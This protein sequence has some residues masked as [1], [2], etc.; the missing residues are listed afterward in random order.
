MELGCGHA[1]GTGEG[2]QLKR[3]LNSRTV[4]GR[5]FPLSGLG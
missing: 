2:R 3:I 4:E 5:D 1:D